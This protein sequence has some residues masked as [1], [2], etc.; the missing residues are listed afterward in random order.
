M[1]IKYL[2][3]QQNDLLVNHPEG[4]KIH[5]NQEDILDIHPD[6]AGPVGTPYEGGVFK[7]K[8][9][10]PSDFPQAPPKGI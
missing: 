3:R 9:V 1:I 7:V 5:I 8:L 2:L 4:V 6:I 10:I